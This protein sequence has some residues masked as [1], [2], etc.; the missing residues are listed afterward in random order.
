MVSPVS[1]RFEVGGYMF[2]RENLVFL[3]YA[4]NVCYTNVSRKIPKGIE[5]DLENGAWCYHGRKFKI[6][7]SRIGPWGSRGG[8]IGVYDR[9]S[10][11]HL[12]AMVVAGR[13]ATKAPESFLNE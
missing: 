2:T 11:L 12:D 9:T 8:V 6:G 10:D 5:L 1:P 13:E 4:A 3:S 7:S